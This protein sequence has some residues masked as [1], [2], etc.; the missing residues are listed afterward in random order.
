MKRVTQATLD[1]IMQD[2]DGLME[3]WQLAGLAL[4]IVDDGEVLLSR[5]FGYRDVSRRLPV[6]SGT[7]FPIG[8]CTKA[9]TTTAIGMLVDDGVLDWDCPVHE[10][11]PDF[12]MASPVASQNI[13]LRDLACHRSGLPRHDLV[14]YNASISQD[15]ILR[16]VR[17]LEPNR[18]FRSAFQYS[19]LMYMAAGAVVGKVTGG[20]WAEFVQERIFDPLGMRSSLPG[21]EGLFELDDYALPYTHTSGKLT[22]STFY[23]SLEPR[24]SGSIHSNLDD[25]VKWVQFQLGSGMTPD[26]QRILSSA[27]FAQLIQPQVIM[28]GQPSFPEVPFVAYGLGW[29]ITPYRGHRLIEHGGAVRGFLAQVGVVPEQKLGIVILTNKD[30]H[31]AATTVQSLILDRLLGLEEIDWVARYR[32]R[33]AETLRAAEAGVSK[34]KQ[35][36]VEAT[37]LSHPLDAYLGTYRHPGYGEVKFERDGDGLQMTFNCL[38]ASLVHHHYDYFRILGDFLPVLVS[39]STHPQGKVTS[40][41]I[42]MEPSPNVAEIVFE[43]SSA[44]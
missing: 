34:Q 42:R 36:Q 12:R 21:A 7:V 24:P 37:S 39:F 19:N 33:H 28:E 1:G 17:Y 43:R 4:A 30:S 41:S 22:E 9:F 31:A 16:R 15:E 23:P 2:V 32:E 13:T 38:K 18:D 10:Y 40:A 35:E 8:S 6:T 11:I 26:G 3:S 44:G 5:G 27:Q 20:T 29:M 25:M 14:W